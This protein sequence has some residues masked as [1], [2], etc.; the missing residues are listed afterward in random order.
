[1]TSRAGK[2]SISKLNT[3]ELA[4]ETAEFD[5]EFVA[6]TFR[7][8]DRAAAAKLKKAKRK[9]G[10]PKVGKGATVI[11]VSLEKGLLTKANK[12]AKRLR[13]SRAQLISRG[14][15]NLLAKEENE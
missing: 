9:R 12:L 11:S 8:P 3:E 6:D 13:I 10:R 2:K 5:E 14:L 7:E 1:M 4:Q 15:R